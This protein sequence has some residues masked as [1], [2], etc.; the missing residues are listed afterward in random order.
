MKI[1][2]FWCGA[3]V[4]IDESLQLNTKIQKYKNKKQTKTLKVL[5][6][7][8]IYEIYF[9]GFWHFYFQPSDYPKSVGFIISN[10][11]CERFNYY[12]LRSKHLVIELTYFHL[13]IQIKNK[14]NFLYFFDFSPQPYSCYISPRSCTMTRTRRLYCFIYSPCWCICFR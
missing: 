6:F 1:P 3:Q 5:I 13:I 2:Y 11:F 10:E 4:K 7:T 9:K 14:K 8:N 12:G